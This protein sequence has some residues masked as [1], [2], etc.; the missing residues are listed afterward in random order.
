MGDGGSDVY[1]QPK[2]LDDALVQELAQGTL[3]H[4]RVR[5]MIEYRG[6]G[7]ERRAR[8]MLQFVAE[9][10]GDDRVSAKGGKG[11]A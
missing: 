11:A 3:V 6:N 7:H 1:F 4:N 5:L 9:E 8:G 10:P 2:Q